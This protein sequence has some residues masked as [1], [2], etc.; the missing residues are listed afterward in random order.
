MKDKRM[1]D[2]RRFGIVVW[3]KSKPELMVSL[4]LQ[5]LGP[6]DLIYWLDS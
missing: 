2:K 1:Q 4:G 5:S 3:A 6:S